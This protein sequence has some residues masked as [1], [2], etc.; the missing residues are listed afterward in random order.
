MINR[1]L[2]SFLIEKESLND[3]LNIA[4]KIFLFKA[5]FS[6]DKF[7]IDLNEFLH[8]GVR[9]DN[10][11]L[12]GL[13]DE[14]T[15]NSDLNQYKDYITKYI[16]MSFI[17]GVN[18]LS[19]NEHQDLIKVEYEPRLP[20]SIFFDVNTLSYYGSIFNYIVKIKRINQLIRNIE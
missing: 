4:C 9:T 14:L 11:Y 19:V 3:H 6:M 16:N 15:V 17:E 12:K 13:I 20:I 8:R 10:F 2:V 1:K 18:G 5:G 7:I